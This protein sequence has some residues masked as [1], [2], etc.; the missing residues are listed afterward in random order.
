MKHILADKTPHFNFQQSI[1]GIFIL[2]M[3][4]FFFKWE[5]KSKANLVGLQNFSLFL[6]HVIFSLKPLVKQ[7]K[8]KML[9][10]QW[11]RQRSKRII[12][13][14]SQNGHLLVKKFRMSLGNSLKAY[15]FYN[16]MK[17]LLERDS[18][19]TFLCNSYQCF[20]NDNKVK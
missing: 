19:K 20:S 14:R 12:D 3:Y 15:I 16:D 11:N 5:E 7:V 6:I 4:L 17:R 8:G 13:K 1:A 10:N 18:H 9:H 2:R